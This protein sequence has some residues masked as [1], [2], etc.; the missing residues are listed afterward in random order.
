MKSLEYIKAE[1]DRLAAII[2]VS[3][4]DSLPSYGYSR[5]AGMPH[6][7]VDATHYHWVV[8]ER[9]QVQ[10]RFSTP[11]LEELLEKIFKSITFD[12]AVSY[13][14]AH[15]IETQDC[16]RMIFKHQVEL[17]AKLSARWAQEE[18]EKHREI[19]SRHPFDDLAGIRAT[20]TRE[21]RESGM[22]PEAA[23]KMACD[24]YPLPECALSQSSH[25]L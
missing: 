4:R 2:G 23:W 7:E 12:Q 1:V 13:E 20:L 5:D 6:V 11:D 22:A 10:G 15:R 25:G 9:G 19:L 18:A 3:S 14:L 21:F 16:R 24:R 8:V 17:L